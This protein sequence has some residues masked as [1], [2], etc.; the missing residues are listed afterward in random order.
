MNFEVLESFDWYNEPGNVR[1]EDGAMLVFAR[2]GV[3]FWQ[4]IHRGLK[5]DDAH[6]F[7]SRK[8]GDFSLTLKW[9]FSEIGSRSQ[10]GIML[11]IDERNWFKAFI[12]KSEYN[13][14]ILSS[15]LTNGGHSDWS[16]F[17]LKQN[18]DCIWF[19]L[20]REQDD[21]ILYYS[22]DG[23]RFLNNRIFY[24][25]SYEDV[26]VGAYIASPCQ[27]NFSARLSDIKFED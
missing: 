12:T 27:N 25:K 20:V 21:Y 19:R 5:K 1:F 17:D 7:Y 26:K 13:E 16:G 4:S 15:S 24:L 6:F 18:I 22:L 2:D 10:C 23:I 9:S 11:R 14:N 8:D 3:D